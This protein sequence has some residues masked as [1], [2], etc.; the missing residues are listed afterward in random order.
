MEDDHP[1][2]RGRLGARY[3]LDTDRVVCGHG[4]NELIALAFTAFVDPGD[5]VVIAQPTFSLYRK[6]AGIAGARAIEVPLVDGVHDLE[7]MLAAVTP[8]TKLVFVCDPEQP[9]RDARRTRSASRLR[10]RASRRTCCSSSIRPTVEYAGAERRRGRHPR[11]T[12]ANARPADVVEDLRARGAPLRLRRT[13]S[14]EIVAWL[15]AVRVPFNVARPAAAAMLAAL[16]D[17]EFLARSRR[18]NEDGQS[19][20]GRG[21]RAPGLL[22]FP[23]VGELHRGRRPG[24]GRPSPTGVACPRDHRPFRRRPADARLPARHGRH[25][26]N[27]TRAFLNVARRVARPRGGARS[28][29]RVA[30]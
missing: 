15:N 29:A 24:R 28:P 21:V 18:T 11:A 2:L 20:S 1:E 23:D 5:D 13:R 16:D 7:A 19:V 14:P 3:G 25:A 12:A 26:A 30:A 6:D 27:K 8:R 10:A 17:D 9:D 4:S 22:A